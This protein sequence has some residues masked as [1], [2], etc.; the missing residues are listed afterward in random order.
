MP[1]RTKTRTFNCRCP[2][3]SIGITDPLSSRPALVDAVS[4]PTRPHFRS[5]RLRLRVSFLHSVTHP[6]F[7]SRAVSLSTFSLFPC[8]F[9][10]HR[11]TVMAVLITDLTL[12]V[13]LPIRVLC[14]RP[15]SWHHVISVVGIFVND[16]KGPS[17]KHE[18]RSTNPFKR[19]TTEEPFRIH[20]FVNIVVLLRFSLSWCYLLE[21]GGHTG[22]E[23][24]HSS[25]ASP[26][27]VMSPNSLAEATLT[28]QL[29]AIPL[30]FARVVN[31]SRGNGSTVVSEFK[32]GEIK[33]HLWK[34]PE[35]P[36]GRGAAKG[37]VV[38]REIPSNRQAFCGH[39]F[40][41]FSMRLASNRVLRTLGLLSFRAEPHTH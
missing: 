4:L 25:R 21:I 27:V 18:T 1:L 14:G 24:R 30:A 31:G 16:W 10:R 6:V 26:C 37:A 13:Q 32:H 40:T 3:T 36:K 39:F 28:K 38:V 11:S 23:I 2:H 9:S 22:A 15:P 7:P 20:L 34:R 41:P 12:Y 19:H 29:I 17:R 35:R 5:Q 33:P 8:S